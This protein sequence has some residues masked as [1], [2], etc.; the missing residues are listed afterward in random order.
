MAFKNLRHMTLQEKNLYQQIHPARLITDWSSGIAACVMF[1]MHEFWLGILL[2]FIPSFIVSLFVIRLADLDS[3]KTT[4]FGRYYQRTYNRTVDLVRF[5]GFVIT[6]AACWWN[7][8]AGIIAGV[9]IILA[10][11]MY[12][13]FVKK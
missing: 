7:F 13:L 1:W 6:A 2:S 8:I 12:G 3:L 5:A 11:W 4:R 9:M 10:T